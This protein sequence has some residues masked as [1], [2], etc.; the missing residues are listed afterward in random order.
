MSD[1]S[2]PEHLP[3]HVEPDPVFDPADLMGAGGLDLGSLMGAAQQ[4]GQQMAEAQE[5][6]AATELEGSAGGGLVRVRATGSGHFIGV[7]ISPDAVD[8]ADLTMLEDLVLAA[9]H[10]VSQQIAE[11]QAEASPMGGLDLGGLFGG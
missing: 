8:A 11:L 6:I 7:Q 10:D 3:T 9:L 4:M 5:R 2:S 1:P